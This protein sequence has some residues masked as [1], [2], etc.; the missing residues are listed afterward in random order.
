M[1]LTL[2]TDG[3][4]WDIGNFAKCQKHGVSIS[5]IEA[6]FFSDPDVYAD[7][8]HS[9]EEQRLRAVGRTG[10]GRYVFVAFTIRRE[11]GL[12]LIRP[13]S[14]RYMHEREVQAYERQ[15]RP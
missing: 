15:K 2:G 4:D 6:L 1:M 8:A 5:E 14:A 9:L 12:W 7:P 11:S 10:E 13:I 3:F